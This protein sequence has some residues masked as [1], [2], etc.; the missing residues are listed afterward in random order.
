MIARSSLDCAPLDESATARLTDDDLRRISAVQRVLLAPLDHPT[1][2]AWRRAVN[3]VLMEALDADAAMFQLDLPGLAPHYSEQIDSGPLDQY[4]ELLP[5]L[6][7][8]RDMAER[9]VRY[10]AG[11]RAVL[12]G[13]HL[14][15]LYGSDYF[16]N[17]VVGTRSFDPLWVASPVPGAP[18]PA[19][20]HVYHSR[21]DRSRYFGARQLQFMRV[22]RPAFEAGVRAV[23]RVLG[24]R[25]SLDSLLESRRDGAVVFGM[26]GRVLH[27]SRSLAAMARTRQ[28]EAA[29]L[30]TAREMA[31]D[32]APGA[33]DDVLDPP[34]AR[35]SVTTRSGTFRLSAVRLGEGLFGMT[36]AVLVTV[37]TGEA[38][39]PDRA[40]LRGRFGLTRRQ[41]EVA[42]LLARRKTS[43]EIGEMLCISE[44]T[45]RS[46][47]E[48]V[49]GKLG[50]HDRREVET[51]LS[52]RGEEGL[53]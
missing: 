20:V 37:A 10:G 19:V 40:A 9:Y 27:R 1:I 12:W 18:R 34:N 35:R 53:A 33:V 36:A 16:H 11:N 38:P 39:L 41:A 30:A 52:T 17:L 49:M 13:P 43:P 15:W 32:L 31:L 23:T 6:E 7:R 42:L 48:A 5:D 4:S 3:G 29:I 47:V 24:S 45:V 44:H 51:V 46:H 21:R 50:V 2:D 28:A 14:D 22:L 26:D 25:A 8:S